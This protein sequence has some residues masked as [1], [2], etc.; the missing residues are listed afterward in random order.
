VSLLRNTRAFRENRMQFILTIKGERLNE[1][2]GGTTSFS[3]EGP[4]EEMLMHYLVRLR[5]FILKDEAV[6]LSRVYKVC[7]RNAPEE[8]KPWVGA[9]RARW[10]EANAGV[11][12]RVQ[13]DN[14]EL[15]PAEEFDLWVNA[16]FH[17]DSDKRKRIQARGDIDGM[18]AYQVFLG[19]VIE[20][21]NVVLMTAMIV[22]HVWRRCLIGEVV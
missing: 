8:F 4:D 14:H 20:T 12:L 1:P 16:I 17:T 9:A 3:L 6:N 2:D 22:E 13:I 7:R 11:G 18:L 5:P 15:N 10:R 19:F 21:S